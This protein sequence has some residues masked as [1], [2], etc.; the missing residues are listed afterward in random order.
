MCSL[1]LDGGCRPFF[2]FTQ[3]GGKEYYPHICALIQYGQKIQY[4][5]PLDAVEYLS[6]KE[7]NLIQQGYGTFLYYAIAI[8]DT[9]L[10]VLSEISLEKS[11]ATKNTPKQMAKLLN[12]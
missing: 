2:K 12:Y 5:D 11:K 6:D 10:P 8:N 1:F 9:V 7:T 3:R 4:A